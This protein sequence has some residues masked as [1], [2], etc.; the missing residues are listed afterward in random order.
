MP[1]DDKNAAE[2]LLNLVQKS[3]ARFFHDHLKRPYARIRAENHWEIWPVRSTHFKT[4]LMGLAY[5]KKGQVP[6]AEAF[7]AVRKILEARAHFDGPEYTLH[8]RVASHRGCIYYDLTD[9]RWRAVRISSEGWEIISNPPILFRRHSHQVAQVEPVSGGDLKD[10]HRFLNLTD[11]LQRLLAE[12]HMVSFLVPDIAHPIAV[13]YGGQGSGKTTKMRMWRRL[14]DPSATETLTFPR[15]IQE[16]VQQL[17]H[18]W[19]PFYDNVSYLHC[20]LSDALCRAVTGEAF[21]KRELY[22]DDDDFIY[23]FRCCVGLNGINLVVTRPDLMDR[24]ILYRLE[25]ITEEQRRPEKELLAEFESSRP[26]LFGA[27]LDALVG[28]LTFMQLN[29]IKLDN[30]PRMADFAEWGAAIAFALG[31]DG[32]EFLRAYLNNIAQSNQEVLASNPVA[33][34]I[35]FHM[36][37]RKHWEGSASALFDHLCTIADYTS[38]SRS[39][40]PKGANGL[41]RKLNTLAPNLAAVGIRVTTGIRTSTERIILLVK[42]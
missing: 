5:R 14:I 18:H 35:C 32:D 16:L 36:R 28:A 6:N 7:G 24:S 39:E 38:I 30:L 4:W 31:Y 37:K 2:R 21:S 40:L 3:G 25:Q 15:S 9:D 1:D 34:A 22:T 42:K 13:F 26:A 20:W 29:A 8:N 12:V 19:A 33:T 11:P 41:T 27:T 23:Q 17:S 10:I